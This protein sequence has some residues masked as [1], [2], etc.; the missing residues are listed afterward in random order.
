VR[1]IDFGT[2]AFD[3]SL[4]LLDGCEA[5]IVVDAMPRGGPPGT[6]RIIEPIASSAPSTPATPERARD[7][8]GFSAETAL[9]LAC[10]LGG[11]RPT[12]LRVVGCE[13]GSFEPE[14]LGAAVAAA[15]PRAEELVL[16]L[17]AEILNAEPG[18]AG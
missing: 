12:Y 1:V 18:E 14:G 15:V 5:M 9:D 2:R 16:S 3:L 13:P 17:V 11:R 4:C 7:P 6:L 8:H 10:A